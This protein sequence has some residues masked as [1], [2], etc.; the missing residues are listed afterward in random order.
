MSIRRLIQ[1]SF[2]AWVENRAPSRAAALA[3]YTILSMAP[4][5]LI[6]VSVGSVV[7]G[8]AEARAAVQ[9]QLNTWAGPEISATVI[10]ALRA[11]RT[12]GAAEMNTALGVAGGF[13][14]ATVLFTELQ[15]SLNAIWGV[16]RG[17]RWRDFIVPRVLSFLMLLII[18]V[19]I[20]LSVGVGVALTTIRTVV[21]RRAVLPDTLLQ[22]MDW[23]LSFGLMTV[24]F[25]LIYAVLPDARIGWREIWLGASVTSALFVVGRSALTSYLS[26]T[27]V[28]SIYGASGSLALVVLWVYYSAQAFFLGAEFTV[29]YARHRGTGV[30]PRRGAVVIAAK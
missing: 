20:L 30:R 7:V 19:L 15:G 16:K 24:L 6:A 22:T 28:T 1:S 21:E 17:S 3:F 29:S 18:G 8:R 27:F 4:G 12:R 23:V 2:S 5:L 13:L 11:A 14:A 9:D 10:S 25:V 26:T